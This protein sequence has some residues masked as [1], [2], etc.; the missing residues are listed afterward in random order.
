MVA[1]PMSPYDGAGKNG[2]DN[3]V[4]P[5]VDTSGLYEMEGRRSPVQLGSGELEG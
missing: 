1:Q 2:R 4:V 5:D 3:G